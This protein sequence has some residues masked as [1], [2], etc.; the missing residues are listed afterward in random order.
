MKVGDTVACVEGYPDLGLYSGRMYVV[1][2]VEYKAIKV[3]GS[4]THWRIERFKQVN[5][6]NRVVGGI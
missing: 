1:T 6:I 3:D 5:P 4:S 2:Y